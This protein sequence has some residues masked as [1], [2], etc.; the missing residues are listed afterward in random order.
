MQEARER[1]LVAAEQLFAEKGYGPVTLRQI[2]A[3][4]GIHHSSLYHHVP[5]GKED[6]FVEVMERI[7]ARHKSGLSAAISESRHELRS[8]LYAVADW[9]L[10]QP[11]MDLLRMEYVDMPELNRSHIDRLSEAAYESLQVPIE[12]ALAAAVARGEISPTDFSIVSGGLIGMLQSLYAVSEA[13]AGK[14]RRTMATVLI[15]LL[16]DGLRPR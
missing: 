15:D 14:S 1:V 13:V 12:Q 7:F 6:L 2:G 5:G 3:R 8:Q 11:P 9:L 4:A 10:S 16:L